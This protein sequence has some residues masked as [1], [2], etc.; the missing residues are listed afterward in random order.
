MPIELKELIIKLKV[1]ENAPKIRQEAKGIAYSDKKKL[2]D[3]CVEKVL[4]KLENRLE[5]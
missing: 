1:D 5:R 3:E 4:E 2:I